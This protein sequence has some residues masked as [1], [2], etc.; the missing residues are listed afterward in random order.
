MTTLNTAGDHGPKQL[1]QQQTTQQQLVRTVAGKDQPL[2]HWAGGQRNED[3]GP[4]DRERHRDPSRDHRG[5]A[6]VRRGSVEGERQGGEQPERE[7]SATE[8]AP[9]HER[10][11]EDSAEAHECSPSP[12]RGIDSS[13]TRSTS[14]VSA[15]RCVTTTTPRPSAFHRATCYQKLT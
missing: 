6:G 8:L 10:R 9:G 4:G 5:A 7:A 14:A 3:R 1:E 2:V 12:S 15:S 11:N 13:T